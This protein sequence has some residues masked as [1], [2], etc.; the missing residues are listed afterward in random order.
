MSG[1]HQQRGRGR[2]L[3][4]SL[5][6]VLPL[7]AVWAI[8]VSVLT[9]VAPA[10]EEAEAERVTPV[11][12]DT[13]PVGS[14]SSDQA[15]S[16]GLSVGFGQSASVA[17]RASGLVTAVHLSPGKSVK[18]CRALIDINDV[19]VLAYRAKAP[20]FRDLAVKDK[21]T[22]VQA[23]A[24]YLVACGTLDKA[25]ISNT[26]TSQIESAVK[27]LQRDVLKVKDTG[28]FATSYVAFIPREVKLVKTIPV[29]I[30]DEVN[31]GTEIISVSG[32]PQSVT[33]VDPDLGQPLDLS[34]PDGY[35][36]HSGETS[37]NIAGSIIPEDQLVEINQFISDAVAIGS[38]SGRAVNSDVDGEPGS[39]SA[40]EFYSGAT[41]TTHSVTETGAVPS[42]AIYASPSG[43]TCV[44]VS[45]SGSDYEPV[46]IS[47]LQM[48]K[49]E[50]GSIG[51]P[52]DLIGKS[53]VRDP[54]ALPAEVATS[55]G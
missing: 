48:I 41:I 4:R 53:V 1:Q 21:G 2:G 35:V 51:V 12:P 26:F 52:A 28:E 39:G 33:I 16:V 6:F 11:E 24:Q 44:F 46:A 7:L 55:C 43:V 45:S 22:D 38:L 19:P 10:V 18:Q 36:L 37:I 15:T 23:L 31:P 27:T 40:T 13:I 49:G 30:G 25:D 42:S 32:P 9:M 50:L 3:W 47:E 20:L 29:T 8:P 14:R 54:T 34:A 17:V 5:I